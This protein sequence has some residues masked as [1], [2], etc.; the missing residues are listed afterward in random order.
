MSSQLI[1]S[2]FFDLLSSS[3]KVKVEC[4]KSFHPSIAPLCSLMK[5][6]KEEVRN[7][8]QKYNSH[9][10]IYSKETEV[11]CKCVCVCVRERE[12]ER[13]YL[14]IYHRR[15]NEKMRKTERV[16]VCVWERERE[17]EREGDKDRQRTAILTLIFFIA[18]LC[19]IRGSTWLSARW[20]YCPPLYELAVRSRDSVT[21]HGSETV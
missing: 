21:A 15:G 8:F 4:C 1:G 16:C 9:T 17:R 13:I 11:N 14:S 7:F 12:R 20:W 5:D 18:A 6:R 10:F 2:G 19:H 3:I